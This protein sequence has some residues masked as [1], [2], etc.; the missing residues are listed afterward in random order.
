MNKK[1][2]T[3]VASMLLATTVGAASAQT[4]KGTMSEHP[5]YSY[6]ASIESGKFYQLTNGQ[7]VL[8]MDKTD[9]GTYVL[10]FVPYYEAELAKSLWDIKYIKKNGENGLAFQFVNL[11]TGLPI[12][13]D[14]EK[15]FDAAKGNP[16]MYYA[17]ELSQ[18]VDSWSWLRGTEGASLQA[19]SA[20]EAYFGAENDSIMTLVDTRN[21]VAPIKYATKDFQKIPSRLKFTV[22]EASPVFLN[23][24]D[25]NTMLQSKAEDKLHLTFNGEPVGNEFVNEF[26]ARDYKVVDAVGKNSLSNGTKADAENALRSAEATMASSWTTYYEKLGELANSNSALKDMFKQ[27]QKLEGTIRGIGKEL[28]AAKISESEARKAYEEAYTKVGE[29]GQQ[30][31]DYAKENGTYDDI[32]AEIAEC[33][34][35]VSKA[36]DD[37][38]DLETEY[39]R[40]K[41]TIQQQQ[42]SADASYAE[43]Q[44]I[45][46]DENKKDVADALWEQYMNAIIAVTSYKN[47]KSAFEQSGKLD[48]AR[49]AL[50]NAEEKKATAV[51]KLDGNKDLLEEYDRA[52]SY[53]YDCGYKYNKARE[54]REALEDQWFDYLAQKAEIAQEYKDEMRNNWALLREKWTAERQKIAAEKAY[55]NALS[56]YL[57]V[58]QWAANWYSLQTDDNK[59]LMV[60]TA[61][62]ENYT[63][64]IKHQKFAVREHA[65]DH[66]SKNVWQVWNDRDINGRFNF[67]FQYFPTQDSLVITA[68]GGNDKYETVTYWKDRVDYQISPVWGRNYVKLANLSDKHQE[69]TLGAPET[70]LGT[71]DETLNT[72]IG[73]NLV[74]ATPGQN[75]PKGVYFADIVN[76]SNADENGARL[77]LDLDGELTKVTPAEWNVM[78]FEDMPAAKWVVDGTTIYGGSPAIK[79]QESTVYLNRGNYRVKEV[80]EDGTVILEMTAYNYQGGR[81]NATI[82]LTQVSELNSNGFYHE[83]FTANTDTLFTLDYLSIGGGLAVQVGTTE[84][85]SIMRVAQGEGTKF[86]LEMAGDVET[87]GVADTLKRAMY[88]IRVNDANKLANN[89][90]YVTVSLVDGTEMLVVADKRPTTSKFFLKEMNHVDGTHY[91]ALLAYNEKLDAY[92]KKA[93]VIDASGLIKMEDI[94][95]ETRTSTFALNSERTRFYRELTDEELG[96]SNMVKFYRTSSTDKEYLYAAAPEEGMTFLAVEGK[97]DNADALAEMSVIPTTAAG[98]LMPQYFIA[99]DVREQKGSVDWCGEDH[100]SLADS[101]AC[102]HTKVTPDTLFGNFLVNLKIDD[103]K[104]KKY[105][106]EGKYTRLAFLSGYAVKDE[107]TMPGEGEYTTLY[108]DGKAVAVNENKHNAA[109]FEFRLVNEEPEQDFLIESE[110]WAEDKE[111]KEQP[112]LGGVRPMAKGGWVKVQNGVPV[113]VSDEFENVSQA[114]VYNVDTNVIPTANETISITEV[115]IFVQ[116]GSVVVKNAAGK[117]VVITTILGQI[118]ANEVLTS[119]YATISVPAGIAIVSVDGETAVK[120][121]VR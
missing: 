79:N 71:W 52:Q 28:G 90:K 56:K 84:N 46:N 95:G 11:T 89:H 92:D 44:Q 86:V 32:L 47:Q 63:A 40:I 16:T 61:Y 35:A 10:K 38:K 2:S 72:R 66:D 43:W 15:A 3:L 104:Y 30:L 70:I 117:N 100:T 67:R 97:G 59:Y 80:K 8:I 75:I 41:N 94:T 58:E 81:D 25:L 48:E 110:S 82:K 64:G 26:T 114:D 99:R 65:T 19:S 119:D 6:L 87:Y 57:V 27:L 115:A 45:V 53:A 88:Y 20:V 93:G 54:T 34:E 1:V 23:A 37:L 60:D 13:Y 105:D 83:N 55:N 17:K 74:T 22:K 31:K 14:P 39:T 5:S 101:L 36:A 85:D 112:F 118:V 121:S 49:T 62:M 102:E 108:I 4:P 76:S 111:G 109:K 116:N 106:W 33:E 77:M 24:Y 91:Y 113:I 107:G 69:V 78:K 29:I 96:D 21:G 120:V 50:Q 18:G 12:S 68:D 9:E 98:T 103:T 73:L 42:E 51:S 7:D